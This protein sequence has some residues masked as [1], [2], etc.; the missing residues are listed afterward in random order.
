V[1]EDIE[2]SDAKA[3]S[4]ILNRDLVQPWM[5]LEFG[6]QQAYPRLRIGRAEDVDVE[7]TVSSVGTLVPMGLKVDA[8]FFNSLLGIPV[9]EDGAELLTAPAP[10]PAASPFGIASLN[11]AAP[12]F[13]DVHDPIAALADQVAALCGPAGDELVGQVRQIV[14]RSTSLQQVRDELKR[15][16]PGIA[17]KNLA[18]MMRLARVVANLTGRASIPNA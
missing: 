7:L 2:R 16:K 15:I 10:P 17:E 1:Q 9:P 12:R 11:A 18:A 13:K 6:P 4:A 14:E 8:N 5:Q 3:L